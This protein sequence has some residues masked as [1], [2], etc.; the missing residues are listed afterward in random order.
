MI[1][2]SASCRAL[3]VDASHSAWKYDP[4]SPRLVDH[5]IENS[6]IQYSSIE[7]ETGLD[8]FYFLFFLTVNVW[9]VWDIGG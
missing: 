6:A 4:S 5:R 1:E 8:Q 2:L 7:G 3:G 9:G